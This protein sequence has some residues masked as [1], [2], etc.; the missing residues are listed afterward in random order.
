MDMGDLSGAQAALVRAVP[1][2]VDVGD[3][4]GI[5]IALSILAGLAAQRSRPRTALR[6]AGAAAAHERADQ[7]N[8]PQFIR[9]LLEGWLSPVL[10]EV[11]SA[12]IRLQAEGRV[13]AIS[14]LIAAGLDPRPEDPWR[15]G[16]SAG[17]TDREREITALVAS[18]LSNR[19]IAEHL[20]LSVRTVETHVSRVLSKLGFNSRGQL[21]VWAHEEGLMTEPT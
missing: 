19:Q 9:A 12:A 3:R 8:R 16:T 20:V 18:G 17:L 4:F 13:M 6:L 10:A 14:E 11:G 1:S 15:V 21:I 5:P 7:T 2:V